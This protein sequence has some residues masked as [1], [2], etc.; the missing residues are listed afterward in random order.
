MDRRKFIQNSALTFGALTLAQQ[1][2]FSALFTKGNGAAPPP[3]M[4]H[5]L[6]D[7]IGV[8]TESGGTIAFLIDKKGVA[9]V[10]AQFPT[11][12]PH[13]IGELKK[14]TDA[15]IKY[16]I[17]THHHGDHTAGQYFIQRFG[18]SCGGT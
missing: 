14:K 1:K 12:A 11:T 3:W 10:D 17:N 4:F 5:M 2:I 6:T 13:F 15:P 9:V 8:F 16:L 7:K 18:R